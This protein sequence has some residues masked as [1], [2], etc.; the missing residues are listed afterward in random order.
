MR[1]EENRE[2]FMS[3]TGIISDGYHTF[4]D[5]AHRIALWKALC[6]TMA[7][8]HHRSDDMCWRSRLHSDGTGF[9]GWFVLGM[10]YEKG[11]QI[12]YHLPE[13]EWDNCDFAR[14]LDQAPEFDGHS[15]AEVIERINA[16]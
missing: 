15:P 9:P 8:F 2:K 4:D 13:R 5:L 16:L 3:N 10:N 11:Q 7:A 1:A 6:R 14:E 12:T